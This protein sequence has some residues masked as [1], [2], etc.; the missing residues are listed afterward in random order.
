MALA[1]QFE[2]RTDCK[3]ELPWMHTKIPDVVVST[4]GTTL[5][6]NEITE[7]FKLEYEDLKKEIKSIYHKL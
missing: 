7:N 5:R 1:G 4:E 3:T 6:E 2:M